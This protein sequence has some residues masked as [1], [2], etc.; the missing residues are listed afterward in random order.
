MTLRIE[1]VSWSVDAQPILRDIAVEV[2]AGEF[3]GV[4]GPNGS[5]KSSLLR[6]VY[7]AL[8]PDAGYIGL[9]GDNVWDLDS[10]EAARR[11]AAVLQESP[12]GVRVCGMGNGVHGTHAPQEHVCP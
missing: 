2:A 9:D 4:L 11:T 10:R 12:R 5:G 8:K 7:R 3:V 6:C 1:N